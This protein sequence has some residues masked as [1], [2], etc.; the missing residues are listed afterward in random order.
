MNFFKQLGWLSKLIIVV[1]LVSVI[2]YFGWPYVQK[3][4]SGT[5]GGNAD[6]VGALNTWSGFA[7]IVHLNGGK[8]VNKNSRLTKEFDVTLKI[9]QMD[10]RQNCIDALK[11]G[12]VDFIY[13]TTDISPTENGAESDL[14]KLGV[15]QILKIDDSR[16]ADVIVGTR[17]IKNVNGLKGHKGAVAVGTA[18]HTLLLRALETAGLT[19]NDVELVKVSDGIEAAK[20]FKSGEVDWAVVWSPDDGDCYTAVTGSHEI[21]ST[22]FARNIIMDGIIVR[23]DVYEKKKE[24]FQ[25]LA[26]GWL[27]I[28]AETNELVKAINPN[29]FVDE[30]VKMDGGKSHSLP[31]M[32]DS[33]ATSFSKAFNAP[34]FVVADG[35][36]KVRYSTHGDNV[37]FFGLNSSFNGVTGNELYTKMTRS[38]SQVGLAKNPSPWSQ[39]SNFDL[40]QSITTLKGGIHNAEGEVV[41]SAPTAEDVTAEASSVR[42]VS[43]EFPTGSSVLTDEAMEIID[44]D[45]MPIAKAVAG[46]S[47]IRLEGNT[48]YTGSKQLNMTLSQQRAQS[49]AN[50]MIKNGINQSY[51]V[52]VIGNGPNNPVC[53]ET[54]PECLARNRRTEFQLINR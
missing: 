48:D 41:F 47:K 23:K 38:Y 21:F 12:K 31:P 54:T 30:L 26:T 35:M 50:Y 3:T 15:Y 7:P 53:N 33:I 14:M 46:G 6:L 17:T 49:V 16:G 34:K 37:N 5:G 8:D 24:D 9:E 36:Y 51:I 19:Q 20:M 1:I 44:K 25:K 40:V 39:V 11:E 32:F 4:M 10:V 27:T 52:A 42:S 13:T 2:S 22:K 43:I 45:I 29:T 28:N 18:S